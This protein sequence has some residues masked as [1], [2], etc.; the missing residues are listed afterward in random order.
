MT[1]E[2]LQ[3]ISLGELAELA[4]SEGLEIGENPDKAAL[5]FFGRALGYAP[6]VTCGSV[7]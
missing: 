6:C 2:R 5:I 3:S 1:R 7:R 4:R